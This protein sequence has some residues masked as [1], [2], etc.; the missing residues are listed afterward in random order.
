MSVV[1]IALL[2]A[3]KLYYFNIFS[4]GVYNFTLSD[5]CLAICLFQLFFKNGK[6]S[7]RD[8]DTAGVIKGIILI[9]VAGA[10]LNCFS[11]FAIGS[12]LT[13][14]VMNLIKRW[15]SML[16]IPIYIYRFVPPEKRKKTTNW[17]LTVIIIYTLTNLR[18]IISSDAVRYTAEGTVNPNIIAG[19]FGVLLI[20]MINSEYKPSFKIPMILISAFMVLAC[21][22]RGGVLAL[23]ITMLFML[24][25][26]SDS[27]IIKKFQILLVAIAIIAVGLALGKKFLPQATERIIDSFVGGIDKTASY[28]SRMGTFWELMGMMFENPKLLFL[29]TGFGNGNLQLITARY[30]NRISTADNMYADLF[31]WCGLIGAPFI[32][33]GIV[34]T[35]K[36][37]AKALKVIP[38]SMVLI[39]IY[40]LALG[41]TQDA[42]FEPT[43][44]CLYYTI[45]GLEI[46]RYVDSE[47]FN[48]QKMT[49]N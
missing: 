45:L 46:V 19:V 21:S 5:M 48:K 7:I 33:A 17:V 12:S 35:L 24:L 36:L 37:G 32:I 10:L 26:M 4:L 11:S 14:T 42:L 39:T 16:I 15:L 44:G 13:S 27:T 28:Q 30:G 3:S 23:A 31:V 22:S 34:K 43:V 9:S 25:F 49:K 6:K 47:A 20:Y 29:G 8:K 38:N 18:G 40:I 2:I 41:F 1:L